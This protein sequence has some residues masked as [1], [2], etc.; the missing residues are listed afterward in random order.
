MGALVAYFQADS[1]LQ[2]LL[3]C[4][5]NEN[6]WTAEVPELKP[7]PVCCIMHNGE[8]PAWT[9]ESLNSPYT[10]ETQVQFQ[11]FAELAQNAEAIALAVK[12]RFDWANTAL[13]VTNATDVSVARTNYTLSKVELVRSRKTEVVFMAALDYTVTITRRLA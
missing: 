5:T 2:N 9:T 13:A 6:P 7:L 3:V 10:E 8:I 1:V 11:V 4:G 12:N